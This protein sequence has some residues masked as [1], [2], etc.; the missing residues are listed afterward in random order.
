MKKVNLKAY[1]SINFGDDLFI[2]KITSRYKNVKFYL[3][4]NPKFN[5]PFK[6][7]KNLYTPSIVSYYMFRVLDKLKITDIL[8]GRI[9]FFKN[10]F[11][12]S[13]KIGGSIFIETKNMKYNARE[14]SYLFSDYIIGANFGPYKT[15]R[16]YEYVFNQ[17][18]GVSDCCFR[19]QYSYNLFSKLNNV[20]YAPDVLFS[21]NK[22]P[23][24]KSGK[25]IG[26]SVIKLENR[27]QLSDYTKIYYD[28]LAQICFLA[29]KDDIPVTLFSFCEYEGDM[30]AINK[31]LQL[32]NNKKN[33]S[34][35]SYKGDMK[36]FLEQLNEVEYLL[37]S[38][39]HAMILGWVLEKKVFPIIYS[40]KHLNVINDIGC[41]CCFWNILKGE[42]YNSNTL[43]TDLLSTNIININDVRKNAENQFHE[44]DKIL[45]DKK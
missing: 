34:I 25:G 18:K 39:F 5:K 32:L 15:Q 7:I 24:L 41:Q 6:K 45:K 37:A 20:R 43:Y 35:V 4:I 28:T 10:I 44:L 22:L 27:E 1:C 17:L 9:L 14:T 8:N 12:V 30:E 19:D 36:K 40:N 2:E 13:V 31:I 21:Y 26:I 42:K 23:S 11:N 29:E 33:V 3:F 38:R 16:F